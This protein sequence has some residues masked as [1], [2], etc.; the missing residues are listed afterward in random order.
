VD[1]WTNI[2]RDAGTFLDVDPARL[3]GFVS[4]SNLFWSRDGNQNRFRGN[5]T[6]ASGARRPMRLSCGGPDPAPQRRFENAYSS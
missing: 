2:V 3:S 1:F 6:L 5:Q 4:D